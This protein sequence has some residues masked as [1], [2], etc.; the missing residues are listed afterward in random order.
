MEG[1]NLR[2]LIQSQASYHWT[3]PQHYARQPPVSRPLPILVAQRPAVKFLIR[4]LTRSSSIK[5]VIPPSVA[6]VIP[7]KIGIQNPNKKS[8]KSCP[9]LFESP[10][11]TP[12]IPP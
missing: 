11:L 7:T 4:R 5:T 3:N 2:F 6:T 12:P 9:S 1:S 10:G 8:C